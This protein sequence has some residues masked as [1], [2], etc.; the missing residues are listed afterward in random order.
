M[1]N[2][3]TEQ[4]EQRLS[5]Q[6]MKNLPPAWRGEI[7]AAARDAQSSRH[8][9]PVTRHGWLSTISHQLSA[10]LWP[11]P[12]AWAGLAAVW[13]FIFAVNFSMRDSAPRLTEKSAPPAPEVIVQ[14]RQQQRLF[15]ELIDPRETRDADRPRIF[16]AKPRGE[17]VE[18]LVG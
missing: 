1:M 8:A 17:R 13:I 9:S 14:L 7:L 11:H 12:K 5:R 4:F 16:K 15:A 6:P 3:E 10:L 18:I 2:E